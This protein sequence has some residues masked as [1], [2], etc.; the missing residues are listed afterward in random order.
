MIRIGIV[1]YGYWGPNLVRNFA[2]SSRF[3]LAGVSDLS[4][5]R[6]TAA[7][8][9]FP[10]V[11]VVSDYKDL[12][13]DPTIDAIAVATPVS[14][15]FEIANAALEAGKNVLLE[16]PMTLEV[17]ESQRLVDL[18]AKKNKTLMVDHTFVY[19]GAVRKMKDLVTKG[20]LGDLLYYDSVRINLGLF[21]HDVNV[22]WDLAPHDLSILDHLVDEKPVAVQ[23]MGTKHVQG[24]PDNMAYVT[25]H[26][27]S[28]FLAHLHVNW[29]APVKIRQ[30]LL[31]GTKKMVVYDDMEAAEKIKVYDRGVDVELSPDQAHAL[32]V[33]YRSG[34]MW[35]P[36]IDQ[37]EALKV[38]IAHFA[39]C[40]EQNKKPITDG[41]AGLRVVKV[42]AATTKSINE[43]GRIV[44]LGELA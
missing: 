13:D 8:G 25:L 35:A 33:G 34:D 27:G 41:E 37:S 7:E 38:E 42:L 36:N 2:E 5:A 24:R 39:D 4:A 18:A 15:H 9:R 19:N 23:A 28:S 3:K 10:G 31:G 30:T 6:R 12:V 40:I 44:H 17:S 43:R 16:K 20:E 22:I 1:G 29:L 11:K 21:Q 32:R 14:T 26:Y